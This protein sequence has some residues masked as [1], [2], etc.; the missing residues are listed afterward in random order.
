MEQELPQQPDHL[1]KRRVRQSF[2]AAANSYDAVAELQRQVGEQ[3]LERLGYIKQTFSSIVDVG[4]GTGYCHKLLRKQYPGADYY[5]LDF[6]QGMLQKARQKIPFYRRW[7]NSRCTYIC[8]DAE[9]IPIADN[10]VEL[11]FSNLTLQWMNDPQA[12][13]QELYRILK[14]GGLL[15]F[16]SL[17]PDTLKELRTSWLAAD[18]NL[19]IHPFIDMHHVGDML[20]GAQFS[21][22]VMD[23]ENYTLQYDSVSDLMCELKH[24][25]AHNAQVQ[26]TT[27]LTGKSKFMKMKQAYEQYRFQGKLP[28]SYEV[29]FG[30]AWKNEIKSNVVNVTLV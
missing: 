6:A 3:I 24:L 5:A 19:R 28:A 2:N 12:T 11:I 4:S 16:S 25:G 13:Y 1:N 29:V 23:V 22:P 7:F 21:D 9:F 17:G 15:M 14:P 10:S 27:G 8:A 20:L 18:N 30:H 26:Q